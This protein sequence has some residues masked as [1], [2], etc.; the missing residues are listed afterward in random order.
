MPEEIFPAWENITNKDTEEKMT[1]QGRL[2]RETRGQTFKAMHKAQPSS[3][4]RQG[5]TEGFGEGTEKKYLDH[6][7]SAQSH[8]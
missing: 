3:G 2:G 7:G 8:D 4:W 6:L 1:M 5:P